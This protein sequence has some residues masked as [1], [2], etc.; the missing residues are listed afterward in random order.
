[1]KPYVKPELYYENFE[2]AQHI[3]GCS[4]TWKNSIDPENCTASGTIGHIHFDPDS[5]N[6]WFL[7]N[8]CTLEPDDY[9]YTPGT[10]NT[11]T[12]NS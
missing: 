12:I 11:A 8:S 10:I 7:N 9:C 4:L 5:N 1:M 2:L 6:A 3:A